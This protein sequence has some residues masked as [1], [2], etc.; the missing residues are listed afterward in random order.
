MARSKGQ[1]PRSAG[2]L[3]LLLKVTAFPPLFTPQVWSFAA[4]SLTPA[5]YCAIIVPYTSA[6]VGGS[7]EPSSRAQA[8]GLAK[9][10]SQTRA[11]ALPKIPGW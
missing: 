5:I 8:E 4:K 6:Q 2:P 3:L 1:H 11:R 9:V 10:L 7:T